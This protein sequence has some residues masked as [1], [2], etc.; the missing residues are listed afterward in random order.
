[1]DASNKITSCS[2][3]RPDDARSKW[4]RSGA[5][6]SNDD[7]QNENGPN[8]DR[9]SGHLVRKLTESL[10]L[11]DAVLAELWRAEASKKNN[12]QREEA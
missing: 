9:H 3:R 10:Q 1:M 5:E 11:T 8:N 7:S 4:G 12:S 2:E 6:A